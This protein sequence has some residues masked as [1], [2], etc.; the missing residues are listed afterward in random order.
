MKFL[1]VFMLFLMAIEPS[2]STDAAVVAPADHCICHQTSA[3]CTAATV[4]SCKWTASTGLCTKSTDFFE[5]T[6]NA[7]CSALTSENACDNNSP[8]ACSWFKALSKCYVHQSCMCQQDT[9]TWYTAEKT[10][11]VILSSPLVTGGSKT[12]TFAASEFS[13]QTTLQDQRASKCAVYY[14]VTQSL[15]AD[16]AGGALVANTAAA[17]QLSISSSTASTSGRLVCDG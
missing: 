11:K 9:T 12:S 5:T 1:L 17:D 7:P 16:T 6:A 2:K 3:A 14:G 15:V 4:N 10:S 13:P 8:I